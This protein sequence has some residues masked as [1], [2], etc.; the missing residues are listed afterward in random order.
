[1][2]AALLVAT[3]LGQDRIEA[4]VALLSLLAVALDPL[5]HQI[6]DLSLQVARAPLGISPLAHQAGVGENLE[7][8]GHRLHGDVVGAGQL[9][10]GGIT[11][12]E[13]GHHVT[14]DRI[15][16]RGKDPR[17]VIVCHG[18]PLAQLIG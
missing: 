17:Q 1:M 13:A 5:G 15:G 12:G 6:K 9:T 11:N 7:V 2:F 10:D 4:V 16:K 8:L 3:V 14:S 18:R